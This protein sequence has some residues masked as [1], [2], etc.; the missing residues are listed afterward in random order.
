M[1]DERFKDDIAR[2][3]SPTLNLFGL[4]TRIIRKTLLD[5]GVYM[6][7]RVVGS[8]IRN[9][10]QGPIKRALK[11]GQQVAIIAHGEDRGRVAERVLG[12]IPA[13]I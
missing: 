2:I 13:R 8:E 12:F 4:G 10:L 11:S 3:A 6:T 7:S 9:R 5:L 1:D